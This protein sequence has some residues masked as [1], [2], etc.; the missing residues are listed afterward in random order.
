MATIEHR[1]GLAPVSHARRRGQRPVE[2]VRGAAAGPSRPLGPIDG[3]GAGS[4]VNI[5]SCP[6]SPLRPNPDDP[7]GGRNDLLRAVAAGTA[8]VTGE[9][10]YRSLTR[11]LAEAFGA[12]VAFVAEMLGDPPQ[13]ARVLAVS[14]HGADLHEGF[15]FRIEGTPCS[16]V[17]ANDFVSIP[18]GTCARFPEDDFTVAPW[19]GLLRR[20][21][22]ARERGRPDRLHRRPVAPAPGPSVDERAALSIFGA[23]AAAEIE[24]RRHEV[25]L[26]AREAEIA[27]SRVRIVEAADEERRRIGRNLHDG[28]QQRLVALGHM[29]AMAGR[30]LAEEPEAAAALLD[31]AREQAGLAGDE[32]RELVR[33][34]HPAGL[35]EH[36]LSH[37]LASLAT[38]SPLPLHLDAL[39]ARRLPGAV[40]ATVYYLVS[41]ALTNALKHADATEVRAEVRLLGQRLLVAVHDD[42]R[43]GAQESA[44]TGLAGL[45]DRI[46]AVGGTLRVESPPGR[47]RGWRRRSRW[48]P[49]A[50]RASRSWSS[51]TARTAVWATACWRWCSTG[52]RR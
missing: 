28:A 37:A 36:G 2:R 14:H 45:A 49:G 43:G 34:L 52:A 19:A 11:H 35:A 51:A 6:R 23:R 46:T 31:Q 5:P 4:G 12:E 40:E 32:L 9:A 18:E 7:P 41:E 15:E 25:A 21:G 29:L 8:T 48:R 16:L 47:A 13:R 38:R 20:R 3:S 22:D 1:F 39:P 24:R 42:G 10:F 26:R 44:G 33:G 30:R 50:P 27:A 17:V